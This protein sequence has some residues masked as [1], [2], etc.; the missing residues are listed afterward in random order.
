VVYDN[1][2]KFLA[3]TFPSDFASWLTGESIELTQLS[4]SEL[5]LEPIRADSLILLESDN[6]VLHLEFQ[7]QSDAEIPF[8]MTDYRLRTYRRFPQKEMMQAVIYLRR[9]T[10]PLVYQNVFE[11]SRTRH[12]FEAIRLWEQPTDIFFSKPGLLPF[13][14][15]SQTEDAEGVL[16]QVARQ[17][18][19]FRD[20]RLQSNLTASTSLLAGLLLD[21]DAIQRI[22]RRDIMKESVIYQ[23]IKREGLAEGLAE[24]RLEA[25]EAIAR[26]LLSEGMNVEQV[27]RLT[28]LDLSRVQQLQSAP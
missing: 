16:T 12:E 23:D 27:A 17:I 4:P 2:C 8:R 15:L 5:S 3:E 20:R 7:T 26:N 14:V 1:I 25:A 24:G 13:A 10:S 28:G 21:R 6:L 18:D 19:T 9:S 11:L 22:L